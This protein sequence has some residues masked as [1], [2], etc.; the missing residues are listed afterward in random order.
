M[1]CARRLNNW[2]CFFDFRFRDE[3]IWQSPYR[4]RPLKKEGFEGPLSRVSIS[5]VAMAVL[6]SSIIHSN[7]YSQACLVINESGMRR[8]FLSDHL[9]RAVQYPSF[10]E[11]MQRPCELGQG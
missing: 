8:T 4:R 5:S 7:L 10:R 11:G 1:I 6:Q 9:S 2:R 3:S